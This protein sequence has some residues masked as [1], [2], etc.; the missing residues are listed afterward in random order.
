LVIYQPPVDLFAQL[1]QGEDG[2]EVEEENNNVGGSLSA[3]EEFEEMG[4]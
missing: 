3:G 2:N 1:K 4:E